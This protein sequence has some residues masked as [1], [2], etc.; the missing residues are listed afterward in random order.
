[1]IR[2]LCVTAAA[3]LALAGCCSSHG[4]ERAA[5]AEAQQ[6]MAANPTMAMPA[7]FGSMMAKG[8]GG[9]MFGLA[10]GTQDLGKGAPFKPGQYARFSLQGTHGG[11][12]ESAYLADDAAGN[13]WWKVKFVDDKQSATIILEALF[14]PDHKKMLRERAKFPQDASPQEL[15]V[16]DATMTSFHR[17]A[18]G[19]ATDKGQESVTVPAGT[20][21]AHHFQVSAEG[22]TADAWFADAVP[23]GMVKQSGEGRSGKSEMELV[24]FGNDAKTELDSK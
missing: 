17:F 12:L 6:N 21:T 9:F 11:T 14:T 22:S 18:P 2:N 7:G 5:S 23:G 16:D 4:A 3:S 15:P 10:F 19:S 13:Q 1:M 8:Y 24:A 20:F